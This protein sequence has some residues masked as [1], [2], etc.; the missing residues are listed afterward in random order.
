[1][2][3]WTLYV[4]SSVCYILLYL[5]YFSMHHFG[6]VIFLIICLFALQ[7]CILI[8]LNMNLSH[9]SKE[10]EALLWDGFLCYEA[11]IGLVT[12]TSKKASHS[13]KEVFK[14][15][16]R[17]LFSLSVHFFWLLSKVKRWRPLLLGWIVVNTN[18]HF[19]GQVVRFFF[20]FLSVLRSICSRTLLNVFFQVKLCDFGFSRIIGEK[21]FRFTT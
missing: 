13:E 5:I 4:L 3:T 15:K 1:M 16:S 10:R 2:G 20:A 8:M 9:T 21:G 12:I 14:R 18:F 7:L 6:A 11:A 19:P 17:K